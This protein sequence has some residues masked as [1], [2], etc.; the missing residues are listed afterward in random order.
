MKALTKQNEN[1]HKFH[2]KL[3]IR[4]SLYH[5]PGKACNV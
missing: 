1:C 3:G 4:Q 5:S 2:E